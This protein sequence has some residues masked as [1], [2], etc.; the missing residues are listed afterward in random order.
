MSQYLDG[1]GG[2]PAWAIPAATR[3][4][5]ANCSRSSLPCGGKQLLEKVRVERKRPMEEEE[6]GEESIEVLLSRSQEPPFVATRFEYLNSNRLYFSSCAPRMKLIHD[7]D[8]QGLRGSHGLEVLSE[9][10]W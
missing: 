4:G 5:A 3:W 7:G 2:R 10:Y 8:A 6:G 1:V 9:N